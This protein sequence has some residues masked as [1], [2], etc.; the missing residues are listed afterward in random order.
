M[1]QLPHQ[2]TLNGHRKI[3]THVHIPMSVRMRPH[4]QTHTVLEIVVNNQTMARHF[5]ILFDSK[6]EWDRPLAEH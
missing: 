6:K 4:V 3:H 1:S 2:V 5:G